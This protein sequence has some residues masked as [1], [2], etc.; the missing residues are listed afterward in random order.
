VLNWIWKFVRRYVLFSVTVLAGARVYSWIF[1]Y[2]NEVQAWTSE[3][4]LLIVVI[5]VLSAIMYAMYVWL[6]EEG[7]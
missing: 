6:D 2:D 3:N 7:Q 1:G 4:R 5:L